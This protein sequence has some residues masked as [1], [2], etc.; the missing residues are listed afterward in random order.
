MAD[1]TYADFV[2][3]HKDGR[4]LVVECKYGPF[5]ISPAIRQVEGY[6]DQLGNE[7]QRAIAVSLA[8]EISDQATRRLRERGIMLIEVRTR[9]P[10]P[11]ENANLWVK[12]EYAPFLAALARYLE[13]E[14]NDQVTR[15]VGVIDDTV[16]KRVDSPEHVDRLF[17]IPAQP[18]IEAAPQV[19][20]AELDR[21]ATNL[22]KAQW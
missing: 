3:K 7:C 18:G 21:R 19:S 16:K 5:A 12:A 2:A 15:L 10:T 17:G 22:K 9:Q 20:K 1:G 8:F 13:H 6:A 11:P 4:V 14:D